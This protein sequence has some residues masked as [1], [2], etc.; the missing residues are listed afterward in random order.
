MA[1][2]DFMKTQIE[3]L[4]FTLDKEGLHKS[5]KKIKAMVS[6]PT[7]KNTKQL[8]SL[9]GLIT[10]YDRFLPNRAEHLK[11]LYDATRKD[12]FT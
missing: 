2:C 11:P 4:G 7:P 10:Y 1:R 8:L 12:K 3:I 6:A 5:E 9:L